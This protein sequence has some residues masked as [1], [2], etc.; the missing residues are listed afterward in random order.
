MLAMRYTSTCALCTL[1]RGQSNG[2]QC[3]L[4][5]NSETMSAVT[6]NTGSNLAHQHWGAIS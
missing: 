4:D 3:H 6:W 2:L 1:S 5:H